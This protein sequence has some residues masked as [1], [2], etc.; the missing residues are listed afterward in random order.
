MTEI[1]R[2][3]DIDTLAQVIL[4]ITKQ[5]EAQGWSLLQKQLKEKGHVMTGGLYR[6]LKSSVKASSAALST[7]MVIEFEEHGRFKDM[8]KMTYTKQIPVSA[9]EPFARRVLEGRGDQGNV[10]FISGMRRVPADREKAVRQLAWA[11]AR[12]R[13][14]QPVVTRL[15]SKGWYRSTFMKSIFNEL[16]INIQA[17]A[18]QAALNTMKKA[19]ENKEI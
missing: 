16:S 19:L 10:N 14:Y 8:K 13:L 17:A 6:S 4:S 18:A 3:V 12:A 7:E 5:V 9:M 15:S 2:N 1:D 11:F